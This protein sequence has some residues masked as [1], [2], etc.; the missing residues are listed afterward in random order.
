MEKETRPLNQRSSTKPETINDNDIILGLRVKDIPMET[1]AQN[2]NRSKKIAR[3]KELR[4]AKNL[5]DYHK[6]LRAKITN[7]KTNN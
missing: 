6:S 4:K 3:A 2:Q 1:Q 5:T 7:I